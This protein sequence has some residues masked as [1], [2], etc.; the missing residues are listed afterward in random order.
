MLNKYSLGAI[1]NP[2]ASKSTHLN[3]IFGPGGSKWC[4]PVIEGGPP[5]HRPGRDL[6]PKTLQGCIWIAP[7]SFFIDFGRILHKLGIE[8]SSLRSTF[9]IKLKLPHYPSCHTHASSECY[10]HHY[11][12][13]SPATLPY[14]PHPCNIHRPGMW[15]LQCFCPS[16]HLI[17]R[18]GGTGRKA[19]SI[20][21]LYVCIIWYAV[22]I[23][24]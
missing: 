9:Q 8:L 21:V 3:H 18:V 6:A 4:N 16:A 24:I 12:Q 14:P 19:S 13:S 5:R 17:V 1:L 2:R 11:R 7:R 15:V 22:C 20:Y 10:T 23:Y